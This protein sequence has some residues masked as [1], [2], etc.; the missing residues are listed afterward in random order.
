MLRS[1]KVA[2]PNVNTCKLIKIPHQK[3]M[4][5]LGQVACPYVDKKV[6]TNPPSKLDIKF[7]KNC[8]RQN[9]ILSH[10]KW[11]LHILIQKKSIQIPHKNWI[12]NHDKW[13]DHMLKKRWYKIP[14]KTWFEIVIRGMPI[15]WY[16]KV[17][18][19]PPLKLDVKFIKSS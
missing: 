5:S 3:L 13:P 7:R 16:K 4:L 11:P 18:T 10:D 2:S 15:C 9:L 8:P 17:N 12:L 14:N 1:G 19:N 6:D